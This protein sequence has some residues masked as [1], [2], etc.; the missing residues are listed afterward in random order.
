M[1]FQ[2]APRRQVYTTFLEEITHTLKNC[3]MYLQYISLG[4]GWRQ[5]LGGLDQGVRNVTV[6]HAKLLD[7]GELTAIPGL[8]S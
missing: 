7:V 8:V 1:K 2:Q 4:N 3:K 5:I 6:V